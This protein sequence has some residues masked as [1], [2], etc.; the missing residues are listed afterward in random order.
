MALSGVIGQV[1]SDSDTNYDNVVSYTGKGMLTGIIINAGSISYTGSSWSGTITIKI[2]IDGTTTYINVGTAGYSASDG[3]YFTLS[4]AGEAVKNIK[5]PF[6][7]SLTVAVK[8][9]NS[10]TYYYTVQGTALYVKE[11]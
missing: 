2:I 1:T 9:A 10:S 8:S 3:V 4:S 11:V 6:A 7:T 5:L